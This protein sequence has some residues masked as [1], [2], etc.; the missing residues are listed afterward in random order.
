MGD[1]SSLDTDDKFVDALKEGLKAAQALLNSLNMAPSTFARQK[2]WFLQPWTVEREDPKH[3]AYVPPP[4]PVPG[5]DGDGEVIRDS[6]IE[7]MQGD[8]DVAHVHASAE[9]GECPEFDSGMSPVEAA[10]EDGNEV[11]RLAE[12][13]CR[14]AISQMLDS[15][16]PSQPLPPTSDEKIQPVV[17]YM[18]KAIYKSTL[19]AELNGNP[20]LSK[21]RLTRIKNSVFFN[22]AEDYLSAAN[23][24]TSQLLGLGSDCGVFFIQSQRVGHS[25]AVATAQ[26]RNRSSGRAGQ[27][28]P[29]TAGGDFG[30]W[31]LGRVQKMRRRVGKTWGLCRNPVDLNARK[32]AG[33]QVNSSS[34]IQLMLNWFKSAPGRNKFKYDVTDTQWIDIDSVICIVA[35]TYNPTN[36]LY[37]LQ[38]KDREVLHSFVSNTP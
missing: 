10:S 2:M 33:V 30:T 25:S 1:Y 14:D 22:N 21:D 3:W 4:K 38:E 18:G 32:A 16:E 15:A 19:V 29:V 37:T 6:E 36:N 34:S 28:T 31:W 8:S 5:E 26:R 24:Y 9:E 20:F 11:I 7:V 12:E 13:E 23:S 17:E 27:P 35:L